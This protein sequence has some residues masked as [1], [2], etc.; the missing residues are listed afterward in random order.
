[1]Q[2]LRGGWCT[3]QSPEAAGAAVMANRG[4]LTAEG[5]VREMS[6]TQGPVPTRFRISFRLCIRK[7][8][9]FRIP[10]CSDSVELQISIDVL[11]GRGTQLQWLLE[12]FQV[13]VYIFS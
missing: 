8:F 1:M 11:V 12:Q 10:N 13:F 3:W 4:R 6:C 5:D 7:L 2:V 9:I